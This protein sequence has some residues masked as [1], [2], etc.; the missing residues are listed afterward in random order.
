MM[1]NSKYRY[2]FLATGLCIFLAMQF[3]IYF[4]YQDVY[5]KNGT[6]FSFANYLASVNVL[7]FF[8]SALSCVFLWLCLRT[9][10]KQNA[11]AAR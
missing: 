11:V 8:L 4:K 2:Y 1:I 6:H 10:P 3:A 7:V 9:F 5:G